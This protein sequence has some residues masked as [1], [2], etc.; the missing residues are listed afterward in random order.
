[1]PTVHG[2]VMDHE[3]AQVRRTALICLTAIVVCSVIAI[4]L[5]FVYTGSSPYK[6]SLDIVV[7]AIAAL[8]GVLVLK[9]PDR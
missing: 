6:L 3:E 7:A 1:M 8:A 2:A 9:K 5:N 4:T